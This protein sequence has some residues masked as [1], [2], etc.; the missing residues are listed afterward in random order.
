MALDNEFML[1]ELIKSGSSALN[2]DISS[3]GTIRFTTRD[4]TDGSTQGY[5]EKPLYNK[6]QLIKAVDVEVDELIRPIN[7]TRTP[8]VLK[9][10][11]DDLKGLYDQAISDIKDLQKENDELRTEIEKLKNEIEELDQELDL[12]K[13]LKASADNER[14]AISQNLE[15]VSLD[16][17]SALTK[18]V[19]EAIERVSREASL[20]G[21][22]AEKDS[23]VKIQEES[24][25]TVQRLN[26]T[27]DTL[28]QDLLSTQRAFTQATNI[29]QGKT[30]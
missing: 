12:Q 29:L 22:L 28:Q 24:K 23:F 13:L 1:S 21:L 19:K 6:S 5:I 26:N 2:Q 7:I 3:N 8:T 17:Q 27:L 10:A 11:Y 4:T 14:D 9:G 18:G 20:Q 30:R 15:T 16:L 25:N